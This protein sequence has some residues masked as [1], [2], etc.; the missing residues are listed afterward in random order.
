MINLTKSK[1]KFSNVVFTNLSEEEVVKAVEHSK[2]GN[3]QAKLNLLSHALGVI[4]ER[5]DEINKK[6]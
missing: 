3:I 5:L 2:E 1:P 4:A 6:V